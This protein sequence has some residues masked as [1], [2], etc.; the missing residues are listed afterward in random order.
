M[1]GPDRRS[2]PSD[3]QLDAWDAGELPDG[4][5][6]ALLEHAAGCPDCAARVEAVRARREAF[7]ADAALRALG[8]RLEDEAAPA[9]AWR[10]WWRPALGRAAVAA[11]VLLMLPVLAPREAPDTIRLKGDLA[12][13]VHRRTAGGSEPLTDGAMARPGDRLGFRVRAPRPGH[14]LLQVRDGGGA[15]QRL[16]PRPGQADT[17]VAGTTDLDVAV[18]LDATPGTTRFRLVLCAGPPPP[19]AAAFDAPDPGPGCAAATATV[20]VR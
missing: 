12:L 7:G 13:V 17:V 1:S 5:A 16:L 10:R 9:P 15:L 11:A 8:R 4:E 18:A 6:A 14:V 20:E 19:A 2:C 3:L